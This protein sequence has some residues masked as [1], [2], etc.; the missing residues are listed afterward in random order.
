MAD[1]AVVITPLDED[2]RRHG[3]WRNN[4]EMIHDVNRVHPFIEPVLDTT[5]G[6]T[7]GFWKRFR[8]VNLIAMG[9]GL[10]TDDVT[11]DFRRLPFA[12]RSVPTVVFDPPYK[13]NGT[14]ACESDARYGVDESTRW[15]DRL[16]LMADGAV[17][18]ARITG[19]M[20]LIKCQDQVCSKQVRWQTDLMTEVVVPQ[21][22]RKADLFEL[23]SYRK[24]P[25]GR[26]QEHSRSDSS[27]LLVFLRD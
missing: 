23:S 8:P 2:V 24:Q 19:H 12:D 6:T 14:P 5:Y 4:A 13:L 20:L 27:Q 9:L 26:G 18:C 25:P 10:D 21:G 17:E 16:Q 1:E 3:P 7:G 22:L 11:A 15:Q